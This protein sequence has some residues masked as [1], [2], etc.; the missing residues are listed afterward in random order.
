MSTEKNKKE[1]IRW[2]KTA[3]EDIRAGD[4]LNKGDIYSR[5]CFH[6]HQAAEKLL[7]AVWYFDGYEPWGHSVVKLVKELPN[8][9][10]YRPVKSLLNIAKEIDRYYIPTRYPNGVPTETPETFYVK[11]D[12]QKT[13]KSVKK[14]LKVIRNILGHEVP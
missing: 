13:K 1:A 14:I 7:K 5:A 3:L 10:K 6:Y 8:L 9:T 11:N 4:I 2:Y 12:A